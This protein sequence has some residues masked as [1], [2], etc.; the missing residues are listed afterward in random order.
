MQ[1]EIN[2]HYKSMTELNLKTYNLHLK[3]SN[4][5]E[6]HIWENLEQNLIDLIMFHGYK[7]KTKFGE[8]KKKKV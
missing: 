3:L 7:K 4:Y 2:K 6:T 1:I 8:R 5:L